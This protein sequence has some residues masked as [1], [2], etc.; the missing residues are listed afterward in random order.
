MRK[1]ELYAR[2]YRDLERERNKNAAIRD[3][4][5]KRIYREFPETEKIDKDLYARSIEVAKLALSGKD[6]IKEMAELENRSKTLLAKKQDILKSSGYG[7]NYLDEIYTCEAC[8]DTGFV[9]QNNG[10][11]IMCDCFRKRLIE[12]QYDA[13]NI[14]NIILKENFDNFDENI[15][16]KEKDGKHSKSP[17]ENI[18][19]IR[20]QVKKGI[21]KIDEKPL[22]LY[23][24]GFSGQGKTYF[25][26][27]IAKELMDREHSVVYTSAYNF[28]AGLLREKFGRNNDEED[29]I[30]ELLETYTTADLLIID[31]LGTEIV[32]SAATSEF[33]NVIDT[34][35]NS[36]LST[37]IS[38]NLAPKDISEN[39]S[40]R[41]TSRIVG[42]FKICELYGPDNRIYSGKK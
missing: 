7:E 15:F 32:N 41:I 12:I 4:R 5:K 24:Y 14:G 17:Y 13:S 11:E 18:C 9:K 25:C 2:V 29:G 40:E 10:R 3:D 16:S 30:G 34:R 37:V 39:Y 20:D 8:K 1:S 23:F 33:F 27:C 35:M 38:S 21:A 31:D 42:N 36:G 6:C 26:H 22:N 28:I 19:L